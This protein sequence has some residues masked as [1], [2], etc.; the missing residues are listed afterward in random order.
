MKPG[1]GSAGFHHSQQQCCLLGGNCSP[2]DDYVKVD[3]KR[4]TEPDEL[5]VLSCLCCKLLCMLLQ[6]DPVSDFV[7]HHCLQ[8]GDLTCV[9]LH[10][11]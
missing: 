3:F 11:F 10:S 9:F 4:T 8:V 2:S 6:Q 1:T 5:K 7:V